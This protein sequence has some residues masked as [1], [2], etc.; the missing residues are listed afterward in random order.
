MD[1]SHR[2]ASPSREPSYSWISTRGSCPRQ[3]ISRR[4]WGWSLARC[5]RIL[6]PLPIG[7]NQCPA[8]PEISR[9]S[10]HLITACN[11]RRSHPSPMHIQVLRL[12]S[13]DPGARAEAHTVCNAMW[14]PRAGRKSRPWGIPHV[15]AMAYTLVN[16]VHMPMF[17][18]FAVD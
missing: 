5:L 7:P 14:A 1:L 6:V 9:N 17:V 11:R 15:C 3:H 4:P 2:R 8:P 16:D 18:V 10:K 13:L 12:G